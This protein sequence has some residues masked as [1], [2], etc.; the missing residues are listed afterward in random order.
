MR[1]QSPGAPSAGGAAG[2][3]ESGKAVARAPALSG[4][5]EAIGSLYHG[6][7]EG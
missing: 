4:E 2:E 5:L 6:A 3:E 1:R 7:A